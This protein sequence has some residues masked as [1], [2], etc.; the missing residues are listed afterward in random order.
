MG[1]TITTGLIIAALSGAAGVIGA[2]TTVVKP[3]RGLISDIRAVKS[4]LKS[5]HRYNM[6][7]TYYLSVEQGEIKQYRRENFES[8]YRAYKALDGNSFIDDIH[9]EIRK[10][11]VVL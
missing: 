4:G 7:E 10:L 2:L 11:K 3:I 1:V 5:V 6:L 9:N 8:E